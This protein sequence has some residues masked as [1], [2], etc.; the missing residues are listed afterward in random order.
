M[1]FEDLP[2]DGVDDIF[3]DDH[4]PKSA[5]SRTGVFLESTWRP[6]LSEE[7]GSLFFPLD[8][9]RLIFLTRKAEIQSGLTDVLPFFQV[10]RIKDPSDGA[11]AD[12]AAEGRNSSGDALLATMFGSSLQKRNSEKMCDSAFDGDL[13][14]VT[15]E[16]EK[17]FD[18]ESA[19]GHGCTALSEASA[20][21]HNAIVQ[22]LIELGAD[23]NSR[24]DQGRSPL[25]RAS[26]NGH[27]ETVKLLLSVGGDP[28]LK[29][30]ES[31]AP[32]H[33]AKTDAIRELLDGWDRDEVVRLCEER[34]SLIRKKT[35]DR[36]K[37]AAERDLHARKLIRD[38][39]CGHAEAGNIDALRKEIEDLVMEAERENAKWPRGSVQVRDDRGQT[40]LM[41][42]AQHGQKN[43]VEFLLAHWKSIDDDIFTG[44]PTLEKRAFRTNANARDS[45]GWT[46]ASIAA[47]HGHKACL[48]L[49]LEHGGDPTL[50]N[51]YGKNAFDVSRTKKDLLGAVLEAGRPEIFALLES[52][53][54]ANKQNRILGKE[55]LN[56]PGATNG[57]TSAT[58]MS[59]TAKAAEEGLKDAGPVA[60]QVEMASEALGST[61]VAAGSG[62]AAVRAKNKNKI[63]GSEKKKT[64][65]QK[66][67]GPKEP[68]K[69]NTHNSRK[70]SKSKTKKK[71][72]GK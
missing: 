12:S 49:I 47:F 60:L 10:I 23:P 26:F 42:A 5:L 65:R 64:A 7:E 24:N 53:E 14:E 51:A 21:G 18:I 40:L 44:E 61:D 55:A 20:Q 36:L 37:N 50:P 69:L 25:F 31:E 34:N 54:A 46:P 33:V 70:T 45:K 67:R 41:I 1:S 30:K 35:E 17:G 57:E 59:L 4:F 22:Y 39:L 3:S 15:S 66:K 27:M 16:I 11:D 6:L 19:D 13:E 52:W 72:G 68:K 48:S 62:V 8:S 2:A 58:Q 29:T 28:D 71:G 38:S 32:F 43:L 63:S 56:L 9:F